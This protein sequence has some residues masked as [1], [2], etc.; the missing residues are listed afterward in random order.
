MEGTLSLVTAPTQEPVTITEA[1]SWARI[2]YDDDDELVEGMLLAAREHVEQILGR[3]LLTQTWDY[4]LDTF[5][6]GGLAPLR[7]TYGSPYAVA[8]PRLNASYPSGEMSVPRPKLQSVT[9]LNYVDGDTM[10]LVTLDPSQYTVDP[11]RV[12]A[13]IVPAYGLVWPAAL[14]VPNTINL[15]F[16]AGYGDTPE[17]VPNRIRQAIKV[18]VATMYEQRESVAENALNDVPQAFW[19]LINQDDDRV[20]WL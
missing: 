12:P 1:K 4:F 10:Q 20:W 2:P 7:Y 15:R 6:F 19:N 14:S 13:R 17:M 11:Y 5:P 3:A 8:V 9:W 18:L 16:V